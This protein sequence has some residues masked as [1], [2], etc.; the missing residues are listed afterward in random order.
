M[1]FIKLT[2]EQILVPIVES[3]LPVIHIYDLNQPDVHAGLLGGS[4]WC[5][6]LC[7]FGRRVSTAAV[8]CWFIPAPCLHNAQSAESKN[9]LSLSLDIKGFFFGTSPPY[10][11]PTDVDYNLPKKSYFQQKEIKEHILFSIIKVRVKSHQ[12]QDK[13]KTIT[14]IQS[15]VF[16]L[17]TVNGCYIV[18]LIITFLMQVKMIFLPHLKCIWIL[19]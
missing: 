13:F 8:D 12:P 10:F 17:I 9:A 1:K 16:F 2:Y 15:M 14:F 3:T 4:C 6:V 5:G 19:M 11:L 7:S 18:V